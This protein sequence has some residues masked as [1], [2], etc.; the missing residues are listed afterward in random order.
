MSKKKIRLGIDVDGV[1]RD[2]DTKVMD[3]IFISFFISFIYL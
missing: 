3:L 2:F 1:L